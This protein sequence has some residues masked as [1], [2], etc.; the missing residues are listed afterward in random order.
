M[1]GVVRVPAYID[2]MDAE[3]CGGGDSA[4]LLRYGLQCWECLA[5][6]RMRRRRCRPPP[7]A[8]L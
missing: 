4:G 2:F 1:G 6:S 7:P 3:W 8:D 5:A